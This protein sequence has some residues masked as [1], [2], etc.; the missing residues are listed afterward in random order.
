MRH[1][2][3]ARFRPPAN[4]HG[5][6][7]SDFKVICCVQFHW[8]SVPRHSALSSDIRL[9]TFQTYHRCVS[10][11]TQCPF[12]LLPSPFC[13]LSGDRGISFVQPQGYIHFASMCLWNGGAERCRLSSC[14]SGPQF[15]R[16]NYLVFCQSHSFNSCNRLAVGLEQP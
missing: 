9:F 7:A 15:A 5:L 6:Q 14:T 3:C 11:M 12:S 4:R 16:F 13:A 10:A 2:P 8:C 1:L